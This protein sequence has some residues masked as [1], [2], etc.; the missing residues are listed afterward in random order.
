MVMTLMKIVT[1][2]AEYS[3]LSLTKESDNERKAEDR[4]PAFR[5]E[6]H[7]PMVPAARPIADNER[8]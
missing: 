6:K 7:G 3:G 2:D 4:E 5:P 8:G 1:D